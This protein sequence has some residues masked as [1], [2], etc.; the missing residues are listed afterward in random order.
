MSFQQLTVNLV[1]VKF[2]LCLDSNCGPLV[3]EATLLPKVV[4]G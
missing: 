1:I 3:L 2:C 4:R